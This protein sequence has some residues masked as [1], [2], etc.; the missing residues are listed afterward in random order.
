MK[1][2]TSAYVK[3][4]KEKRINATSKKGRELAIDEQI[5]QFVTILI[6]TYLKIENEK[7]NR[8]EK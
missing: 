4:Q 7:A 5:D 6:N 3:E 2:K 1:I 8:K